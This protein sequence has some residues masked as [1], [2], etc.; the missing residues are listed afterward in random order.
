MC[1]C[2]CVRVDTGFTSVSVL[3]LF[4]FCQFSVDPALEGES[5]NSTIQWYSIWPKDSS[6]MQQSSVKGYQNGDSSKIKFIRL[7]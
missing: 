2:V 5:H 1:V 3:F 7:S 6:I 4:C